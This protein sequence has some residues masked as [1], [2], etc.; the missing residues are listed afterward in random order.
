M[1][2]RYIFT[3]TAAILLLGLSITA[4]SARA[5]NI[6]S[7]STVI[8]AQSPD[9]QYAGMEKKSLHRVMWLILIIWFGI[10]AYL[11]KIDRR[12]ARLEKKLNE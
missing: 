4:G 7:N 1:K 2:I 10:G 8:V 9:S 3:L 11:F 6:K 5:Q 12:I